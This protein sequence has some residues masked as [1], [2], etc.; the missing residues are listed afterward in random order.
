MSIKFDFKIPLLVKTELEIKN[1]ASA[2]PED[3]QN[4]STHK[5]DVAYLFPEI[6]SEKILDELPL[7]KEF[8][9]I[10]YV[11]GAIY[12]TIDKKNYN[13]SNLNKIISHRLYQFMTIRNVN[14]ARYLAELK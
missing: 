6:H 7:K 2:I 1:I 5:T 13:K 8:I 12:W 4:N 3:W 10:H 11:P 9:D 14:T